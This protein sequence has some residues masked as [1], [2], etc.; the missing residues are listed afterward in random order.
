MARSKTRAS[1]RSAKTSARAA[2]RSSSTK[3]SAPASG[4]K[5]GATGRSA[6]RSRAP[7]RSTG[8]SALAREI[9]ELRRQV[10][11][12]ED[13]HAVRTLH[14]K[15]GY[16]I[17]MCLY[18]EATDLFAEDGEVRF[19][20]GVYK[21]KAGVRRLYCE[22]FRNLFTQG[23]NGPV[24]GF[25][26]DHLQLQDIVDIAP[27]GKTAQGRFRAVMMAGQH[28][29]K[30]PRIEHFPDQCWEAGIYENLYVKENGVWKIKRL[31]YNMLWQADYEPGWA[32]SGVHLPPIDKTFPENPIGP[33]ELLPIT[34]KVWPE[35]RVVPF[36][37]AH[38]VTG[39][40]WK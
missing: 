22:W 40:M 18:D 7:S 38:P 3:R 19:L 2:A 26:L 32:K 11:R 34:P 15:Y 1:A 30:T 31:N 23:H 37:Y 28:E 25:L 13:I 17:D 24:R 27:D 12:L 20:N 10:T 16:Y 29:S 21:G 4:G 5:R 9:A 35:T 8:D 14:F 36:H 39:K 33:D 6:T